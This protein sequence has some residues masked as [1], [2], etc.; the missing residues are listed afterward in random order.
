MECGGGSC[1]GWKGVDSGGSE[2]T[3]KLIETEPSD[4]FSPV[5]YSAAVSNERYK[6]MFLTYSSGAGYFGSAYTSNSLS[7]PCY[8]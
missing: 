4:Y 2:Y 8:T 1:E 7:C 3:G 6:G 5:A